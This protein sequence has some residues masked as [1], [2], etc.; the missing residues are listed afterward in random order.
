MI[1]FILIDKG[2]YSPEI[3]LNLAF[4]RPEKRVVDDRLHDNAYGSRVL[5]MDLLGIDGCWGKMLVEP[6][7]EIPLDR[8]FKRL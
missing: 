6:F 1:F 7:A 5:L 3:I 4:L 2:A 8:N